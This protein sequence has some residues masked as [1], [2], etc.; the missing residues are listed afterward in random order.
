MSAPS[1]EDELPPH[2]VFEVIGPDGV[3]GTCYR[4]RDVTRGEFVILQVVGQPF[5]TPDALALFL[6][7]ARAFARLNLPYVL[8]VY[9]VGMHD[10][11]P[12]FTTKF[13]AKGSLRDRLSCYADP[14]AAADLAAKLSRGAAA[15][16]AHGLVHGRLG[17]AA[18]HF[19]ESDQPLICIYDLAEGCRP[20]LSSTEA[21]VT[22]VEPAADVSSL[23]ALLH[24]LLPSRPRS[25]IDRE[26]EAVVLRCL[27]KNPDDR[28]GSARALADDLERWLRAEP[29]EARPEPWWRRFLRG[30]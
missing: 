28:Y 27:H 12:C 2:E 15:A 23:G 19:D 4:A 8:P 1:P 13:T 29:T 30:L 17:P 21:S 14:R 3:G 16:H 20:S 7:E 5:A 25:G 26:L 6:H 18:V 22:H 24:D 11:R 10:G 9:A